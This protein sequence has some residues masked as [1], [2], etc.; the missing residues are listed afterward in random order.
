MQTFG[1]ELRQAAVLILTGDH[2]LWA[3]VL[4]SLRVSLTAVAAAAI[5]DLLAAPRTQ[6]GAAR[7]A[8]RRM[9]C[10]ATDGYHAV[11]KREGQPCA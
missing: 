1:D 9:R 10:R 8:R 4:L 3:I 5:A 7:T 2:D 11:D 6:P